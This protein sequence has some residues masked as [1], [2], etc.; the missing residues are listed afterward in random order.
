MITL[1]TVVIC[2]VAVVVV[3]RNIRAPAGG[4]TENGPP[5]KVRGVIGSEKEPF[6]RDQRV[7]ERFKCV[8]LEV[9]VDPRGSR[10]ML[11]VLNRPGHG[12]GFAFPSSTPTAEKIMTEL[13]VTEQFTPFSTPMVVATFDPIVKVLTRVGVVQRASDG[14]QVVDVAALLNL[15]QQS[16]RWDQLDG[17]VE[18]HPSNAVLLRTTDPRDSNSAIMFLSIASHVANNGAV[19]TT[20]DQLQKVMPDLCRLVFD[21]GTKPET[22]QVLFNQYV[23][24]GIGRIP[25]ALIYESQVLAAPPGQEPSLPADHAV[26]YPRPTVYSRHTLIPLDDAGRRVGRLLRDDPELRRLEQEY[27][28]R[29]EGQ[30]NNRPSPIDVI[31]SPSYDL[32]EIMLSRLEPTAENARRCAK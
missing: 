4:C 2:L 8:G 31:E 11:P 20:Q 18:Y 15:V 29:P 22:S 26:L 16:R 7:S 13:R 32:L 24:D 14:S 19:V 23:T 27:G 25:M 21:Q 3:V 28:F 1:G 12:Y 10:G 5:V 9:T 6:F 30:T 17:N